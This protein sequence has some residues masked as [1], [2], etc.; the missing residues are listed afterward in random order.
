[1]IAMDAVLQLAG[2]IS[3]I[4]PI[5]LERGALTKWVYVDLQE[6]NEAE[7]NTRALSFLVLFFNGDLLS[8]SIRAK[9][10]FNLVDVLLEHVLDHLGP[11]ESMDPKVYK[12][13][14]TALRALLCLNLQYVSSS[15]AENK[16]MSRVLFG[17]HDQQAL[18]QEAIKVLSEGNDEVSVSCMVKFLHDIFSNGV[19]SKG[20]FFQNDL[21]VL[22]EV[23]ERQISSIDSTQVRIMYLNMLNDVLFAS[24]YYETLHRKEDIISLLENLSSSDH[25][26]LAN[27]AKSIL[28]TF[29]TKFPN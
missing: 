7:L 17:P 18:C 24:D 8:E 13:K 19:V 28:D 29:M 11:S 14:K 10:G 21:K 15:T 2:N 9:L 12:M 23:L 3:E 20:M 5:L 1:M 25:A 26:T 22:V 16:V 4:V 6:E 27:L